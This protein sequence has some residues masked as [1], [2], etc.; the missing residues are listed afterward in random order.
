MEQHYHKQTKNITNRL[1]RIEGHVRAVK[2]MVDSGKPCADVLVQISAIRSAID[3]VGR[4][5]LEDHIEN[6]LVNSVKEG[7]VEEQ[8]AELKKALDRFIS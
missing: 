1:S 3:R 2:Q 6:C 8:L 4:I 7:N 5:L